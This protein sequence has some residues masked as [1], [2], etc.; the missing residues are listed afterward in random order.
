VKAE[1]HYII[2]GITVGYPVTSME[3]IEP[4]VKTTSQQGKTS[5]TMKEF[6]L[7]MKSDKPDPRQM[8]REELLKILKELCDK[9][10][11]PIGLVESCITRMGTDNEKPTDVIKDLMENSIFDSTDDANEYMAY[12]MALYNK[13]PQKFLGGMSPEEKYRSGMN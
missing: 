10:N 1:D 8:S 13:T 9:A 4:F 6:L 12:F 7:G 5:I 11:I 2:T 3:K